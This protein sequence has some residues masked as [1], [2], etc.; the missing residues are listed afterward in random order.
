MGSNPQQNSFIVDSTE[1]LSSKPRRGWGSLR[2][3]LS[4]IQYPKNGMGDDFGAP[5]VLNQSACVAAAIE[6]P[7]KEIGVAL[8][9]LQ[10]CRLSLM[11]LIE[12]SR[13]YTTLLMVLDVHRPRRLVVVADRNTTMA[14]GLNHA[15]REFSQVLTFHTCGV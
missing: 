14:T 13:S 10:A 11:Q 7:A 1:P 9:D 15:A 3:C 4:G 8:L 6:N 12:S 2:P 5:G